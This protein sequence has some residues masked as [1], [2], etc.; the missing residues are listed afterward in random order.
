MA[1]G[2]VLGRLV[3]A[4]TRCA[5]PGWCS[6]SSAPTRDRVDRRAALAGPAPLWLLVVLVVVLAHDG[7]GSMIGFDFAR[8]VQPARAARAR[9]TGIVNV[10]G[11]VASLL[12]I[13]LV[14]VVLDLVAPA[15]TG[16]G[17][18]LDAFRAA[19]S[20]QYVFWAIGLVG[21]AADPPQGARPA[22]PRRRRR[23]ADP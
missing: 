6:A 17:Y 20:V 8:T 13:L 14:G 5:G 19:L 15:A 22:G 21:I 16:H 7:P 11:F 9:A 23:A 10:G 18:S 4:G 12:T 2:P 3:A 1:V